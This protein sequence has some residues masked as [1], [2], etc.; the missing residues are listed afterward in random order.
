MRVTRQRCSAP[1]NGVKVESWSKGSGL[2][3]SPSSYKLC[4]WSTEFI[5]LRVVLK[6]T[7]RPFSLDF[8]SLAIISPRVEVRRHHQQPSVLISLRRC[9]H[10]HSVR[11]TTARDLVVLQWFLV[12]CMGAQRRL[13]KLYQS[14]RST[15]YFINATFP[16]ELL[17]SGEFQ[18]CTTAANFIPLPMWTASNNCDIP[19]VCV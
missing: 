13:D 17:I 11:L 8:L 3:L 6:Q 4:L 2:S 10:R 5:A 19:V 14:S 15:N 9:D 16:A 1:F 18:A 12:C 7:A